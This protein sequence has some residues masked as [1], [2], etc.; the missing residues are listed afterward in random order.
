MEIPQKSG[1]FEQMELT[2]LVLEPLF[3]NS[4][5]LKNGLVTHP[6]KRRGKK[7]MYIKKL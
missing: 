2:V 1:T 6:P 7:Y 3:G 4:Y 5:Q